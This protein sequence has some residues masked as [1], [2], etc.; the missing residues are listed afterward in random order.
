V[1]GNC[2]GNPNG[3][4][5]DPTDTTCKQCLQDADCGNPN[6]ACDFSTGKCINAFTC[7]AITV[8][9]CDG[10]T[11]SSGTPGQTYCADGL[12]QYQCT[13]PGQWQATGSLCVCPTLEYFVW[14]GILHNNGLSQFS[15]INSNTACQA[16]CTPDSNCS[17]TT[18]DPSSNTCH[19]F[20]FPFTNGYTVYIE[21][22][23]Q[24]DVYI[25]NNNTNI[26]GNDLNSYSNI[27]GT[28]CFA[29]CQAIGAGA[30]VP[31]IQYQISG[32]NCWCKALDQNGSNGNWL[33]SFKE[34]NF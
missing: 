15:N 25:I 13:S 1:N 29:N 12:H 2:V 5:C 4:L 6:L 33:T 31:I 23:L 19:T 16:I 27:S 21:D 32:G 30:G 8:P 18:W 10:S 28:Q 24:S 17:G 26:S 20:T 14:N 34:V 11:I 22:P 3:G 9:T 7:P